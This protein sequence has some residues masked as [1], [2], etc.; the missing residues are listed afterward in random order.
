MIGLYSVNLHVMGK[1]NVA[2]LRVDTIFSY[3]E[4]FGMSATVAMLTVGVVAA[5]FIGCLMYWFLVQKLAQQ[6]VRQ[7]AIPRWPAHRVSTPIE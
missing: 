4:S 6:S 7:G 3:A 1:A 2:L 5:V